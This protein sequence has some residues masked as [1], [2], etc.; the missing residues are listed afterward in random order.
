MSYL[1]TL[2]GDAYK[3]GMTEAEISSALE[4]MQTPTPKQGE[5]SEVLKLKE[6]ISKAN[7]EAAR[8]KKQLQ[9]KM[10]A[11]EKA[12]ADQQEAL[13][14]L[15]A[16]NNAMKK[17][18]AITNNKAKLVGIGYPEDLASQT[19]EA[20]FNGDMDT[21]M[22]NQRIMFENREKAIRADVLRETP[23]PP[24]GNSSAGITKAE[25]DAMSLSERMELYAKDQALY[26]KLYYGK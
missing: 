8:Y 11:E 26:E 2:L 23:V 9:E 5:D 25:F 18:I 21:V 16:D 15:I 12:K 1:K 7:S 4:S 6:A 3:E 17:Q 10:S 20:M 24:A 13:D 19:A 14:K 22:N